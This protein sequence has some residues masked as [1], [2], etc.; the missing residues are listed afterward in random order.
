MPPI[1]LPALSIKKLQR[2]KVSR[3]SSTFH[4]KDST[5]SRDDDEGSTRRR[6]RRKVGERFFLFLSAGLP[7]RS[8]DFSGKV[9][10]AE[11]H[12]RLHTS[13]KPV[14]E[15]FGRLKKQTGET[16]KSGLSYTFFRKKQLSFGN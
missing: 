12:K 9:P 7:K 6:Y 13:D 1:V 14:P 10:E 3:F 4:F 8:L 11:K 15:K 5:S 16:K 2:N